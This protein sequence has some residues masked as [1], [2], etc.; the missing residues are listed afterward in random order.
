MYFIQ[1]TLREKS[2]SKV[3]L[4][5]T[6]SFATLL[7]DISMIK[8][9]DP[10]TIV[11]PGSV[12]PFSQYSQRSN[13]SGGDVMID[14]VTAPKES[15][16]AQTI[17]SFA[18]SEMNLSWEEMSPQKSMPE[19]LPTQHEDE[20]GDTTIVPLPELDDS[21]DVKLDFTDFKAP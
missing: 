16:D 15:L 8:K 10:Q 2:G 18:S 17:Q 7:S 13:L 3:A 14:E 1:V 19:P 12:Y 11:K 5:D 4:N 21:P 9:S 20:D 6:E